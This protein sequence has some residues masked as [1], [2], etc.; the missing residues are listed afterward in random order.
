MKKIA[1]LYIIFLFFHLS[2]FTQ[3]YVDINALLINVSNGI[4][5]WG[6]YDNDG[7]L[8]CFV[9]GTDLLTLNY[10][11]GLYENVNGSFTL[12]N[13]NLYNTASTRVQADW[14]D[15]DNDG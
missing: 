3:N 4:T 7:D 8:D 12:L 5:I 2:G 11:S 14:G 1:F 15:Y 10:K 13:N 9:S 6:D